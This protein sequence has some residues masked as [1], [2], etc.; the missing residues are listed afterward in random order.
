MKRVSV[1]TLVLLV[2]LFAA[3]LAYQYIAWTPPAKA[4]AI[5]LVAD[6]NET[7]DPPPEITWALPEGDSM[8]CAIGG[9]PNEVDDDPPPESAWACDTQ[10]GVFYAAG[11]DPNE[12]DDDPPP[13][14]A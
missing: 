12:V 1:R 2:E 8:L 3:V 11:S 13:E 4:E 14:F 9:D 6:P 5:W 7:D 10:A